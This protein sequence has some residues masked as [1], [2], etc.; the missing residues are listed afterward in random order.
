VREGEDDRGCE[1]VGVVGVVDGVVERVGVKEEE[2]ECWEGM[3]GI[4]VKDIDGLGID[5]I[6]HGKARDGMEERGVVGYCS[7]R[8]QSL[9][10]RLE[11][12]VD[13]REGEA[14]GDRM[15]NE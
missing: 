5:G 8:G 10:E 4:G 6:G 12:V 15:E 1:D 9:D 2:D 11:V 14:L 3:K 13:R 7:R